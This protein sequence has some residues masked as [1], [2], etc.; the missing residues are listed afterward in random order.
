MIVTKS[1]QQRYDM[2]AD[3]SRRF[4]ASMGSTELALHCRK[5]T[6]SRTA[7]RR[8]TTKDSILSRV[9]DSSENKI[10]AANTIDKGC[11]SVSTI[12]TCLRSTS[13]RPT[14]D[15]FQP[16]ST[17]QQKLGDTHKYD[18]RKH[19]RLSSEAFS[20]TTKKHRT[21]VHTQHSKQS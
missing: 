10:G 1:L 7:S 16:N 15:S 17:I 9:K 2:R 8:T 19:N 13:K 12:S 3:R 14:N 18:S 6:R 5:E 4:M 20:K 11:K 21:K